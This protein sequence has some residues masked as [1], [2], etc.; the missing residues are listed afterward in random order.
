MC[1]QNMLQLKYKQMCVHVFKMPKLNELND[2]NKKDNECE[3]KRN[4]SQE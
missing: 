2:K 4:E 3:R 1:H